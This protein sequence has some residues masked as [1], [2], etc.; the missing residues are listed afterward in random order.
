M[1]NTI[2]DNWGL[3]KLA[4]ELT[5]EQLKAKAAERQRNVDE[6]LANW[7]PPPTVFDVHDLSCGCVVRT[8]ANHTDREGYTD[9]VRCCRYARL[10]L[11][12]GTRLDKLNDH[13]AV[14]PSR[15]IARG[16]GTEA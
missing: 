16:S 3:M 2:A 10:V 11:D 4:D 8:D 14:T 12:D 6:M 13:F 9:W 7:P 1:T 5:P 15:V